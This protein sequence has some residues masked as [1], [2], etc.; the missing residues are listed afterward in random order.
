MPKSSGNGF[1]SE[2]IQLGIVV[3]EPSRSGGVRRV[4][5]G[6]QFIHPRLSEGKSSVEDF[7]RLVTRES[8]SQIPEIHQFDDLLGG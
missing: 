3:A 5:S 8:V 7:E 1:P 4:P 6:E 2:T